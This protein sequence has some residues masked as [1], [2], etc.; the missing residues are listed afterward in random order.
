[1]AFDFR[2]RAVVKAQK[3]FQA[4]TRGNRNHLIPVS[5]NKWLEN[6]LY[7]FFGSDPKIESHISKNFDCSF[8]CFFVGPKNDLNLPESQNFGKSKKCRK[9][10]LA[11]FETPKTH[12][13]RRFLK[14]PKNSDS[15]E[16][17]FKNLSVALPHKDL[18]KSGF[19][20]RLKWL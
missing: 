19:Q 14:M 8:W 3:I 9:N 7:F 12:V 1:M 16:F 5:S 4:F 15:L 17:S 20:N 18:E 6:F 13:N 10:F 11:F 2:I